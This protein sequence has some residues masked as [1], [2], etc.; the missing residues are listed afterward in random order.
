MFNRTFRRYNDSGTPTVEINYTS[1]NSFI[2]KINILKKDQDPVNKYY[3]D[4]LNIKCV[5][6]PEGKVLADR[7]AISTEVVKCY[8][9]LLDGKTLAC[10][11]LQS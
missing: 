3:R 6:T 5:S 9:V 1:K 10:S 4:C 8:H 11:S 7:I 2:E